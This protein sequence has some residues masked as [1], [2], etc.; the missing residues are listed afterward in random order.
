MLPPLQVSRVI[1]SPSQ[2]DLYHRLS[3]SHRLK[4]ETRIKFHF[5][6]SEKGLRLVWAGLAWPESILA[7]LGSGP[8]FTPST[9]SFLVH[10]DID[11]KQNASCFVHCL[12]TAFVL[13]R[14]CHKTIQSINVFW[15]WH[16]LCGRPGHMKCFVEG[17]LRPGLRYRNWNAASITSSG[18]RNHIFSS[19]MQF[20]LMSFECFGVKGPNRM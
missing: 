9:N 8:S 19:L 14:I 18:F 5:F 3:A 2:T 4:L 1:I 6:S 12:T 11:L 13:L 20:D 16:L 15:S 17:G 7:L 10:I